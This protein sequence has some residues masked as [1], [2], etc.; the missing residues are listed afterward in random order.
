MSAYKRIRI[1]GGTSE[2][3]I[4]Y[5]TQAKEEIHLT[6]QGYERAF[7]AK[8]ISWDQATRIAMQFLP[9]VE[10]WRPD[11]VEEVRGIATGSDLSFEDIFTINCRTEVLWS[12]AREAANKLAHHTKGE[13]SSFAI[14]PDHSTGRG[15]LVGQNWDWLE[16]LSGTVIVLEVERADAPNYVTIVEG[17]LL[18]KTTLNQAGIA[19]AINTLVSSLDGK[20]GGIPFHFLIRAVVDSVSVGDAVTTLSSV[21]R[22]S[23]GNYVLGGSDG[24]ILNIETAPGDARNVFPVVAR[25]R[26]VVHTNHFLN[27]IDGGFDLA[28]MQMADSYVRLGRIRSLIADSEASLTLSG[29]QAALGD[30]TDA[31]SAI[32]CHPDG[33]SEENA[34]WATL[35]SVV[36]EPSTRRIHLAEGLPCASPW[37]VLD[38][39]DLLA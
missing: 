39:S 12:A 27:P 15:T 38:Y 11:L 25:R 34:R 5:G 28:P 6:R 33:D 2:R 1:S 31:P 29:I 22:A 8:G 3:S 26:T 24:A 35:A 4:Q 36:M 17:G 37:Q 19:L 7:A 20:P 21:V 10:A 14:E 16:T 32:C 18:A 13:C 23:S 9:E 30:H